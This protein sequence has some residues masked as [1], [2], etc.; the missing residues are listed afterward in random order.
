[1]LRLPRTVY[2][3]MAAHA[4]AEYPKECLRVPDR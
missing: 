2:E 4:V 3:G 1:M